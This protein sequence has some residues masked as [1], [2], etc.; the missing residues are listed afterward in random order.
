MPHRRRPLI[1]LLALLL[2]LVC[3]PPAARARMSAL[4]DGELAAVVGRAGISIDLDLRT[5]VRVDSLRFSDSS[6]LP[7]WLELRNFS[8][9]NGAGEGF[10]LRS[11]DDAG[12]KPITYDVTT[13][14]SGRTLLTVVDTSRSSPRQY[15]ADE[16][17]FAGQS[18]GSLRIG[19]V[20]EGTNTLRLGAPAAGA[21][22]RIDFDYATR[23]DVGNLAW[24][25]GAQ[26]GLALSGVHLFGSASAAVELDPSQWG[27]SG[28]FKIG[29]LD[30]AALNP[31]GFGLGTDAN[32][33]SYTE[34]NLPMRGSFRV[35]DV[36][37][38][39]SSF[40]PGAV[41]GINVHRLQLRFT[42]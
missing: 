25:Y 37:V 30:R 17:L 23:I 10:L 11:S 3:A 8:I 33:V 34:L 9:D 4:G 7:N 41:D 21:G 14:A 15:T 2:T 36:N 42:P 35:E 38:G 29:E 19:P 13:D 26:G 18:L 28:T 1:S 20:L 40:G 32:G 6:P 31:A 39:G 27:T 12:V 16:L 24:A 5:H 22:S